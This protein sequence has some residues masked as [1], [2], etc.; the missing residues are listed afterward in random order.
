MVDPDQDS[1]RSD[2]GQKPGPA[3]GS[4]AGKT[5]REVTPLDAE[6][7][8]ILRFIE[9]FDAEIVERESIDVTQVNANNDGVIAPPF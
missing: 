4:T 9:V 5:D 7:A 6:N 1:L 3:S 2:A 8:K